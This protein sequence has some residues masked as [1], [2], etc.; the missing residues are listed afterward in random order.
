MSVGSKLKGAAIGAYLGTGPKL[1]RAWHATRHAL[2]AERVVTFWHQIDDPWSHLLAQALTRFSAS[3]PNVRLEPVLV[4]EP[5]ADADAEP[6][7]RILYG[8]ADARRLAD[9]YGLSFPPLPVLPEPDRLR[10]AQAV[11]LGEREPDAWLDAAVRAGDAL[12]RGDGDAL[13]QLVRELGTVPGQ[14]VRPALE[15]SYQRLRKSGHYLGGMLTYDGE[16]YWGLDRLPYLFDRLER[17]GAGSGTLSEVASTSRPIALRDGRAQAELYLSFRS[18]YSYLASHQVEILAQRYPLDVRMRFIL[19][20]VARG[21]P[22]PKAKV[23]YIAKDAKREAARLQIPFG[24]ILDPLGEGVERALA[25]ACTTRR[26]LGEAAALRFARVVGEGVWSRAVDLTT[27]EGLLDVAS[28]AG[29]EALL[30]VALDDTSW[31]AEVDA[32]AVALGELG[33]WG[34]PSFDLGDEVL[35]GRDRIRHLERRL[36]ATFGPALATAI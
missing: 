26:E 18:P 10:R 33:L 22:A 34:V 9:A 30:P 1:S 17:E 28:R 25:L 11:L 16:H 14:Q 23:R 13:S 31:R 6:K 5:A 35:W 7:K 2:R 3:F 19:P 32:N 24:R 12:F 8:L 15:A 21:I 20:M 36:E 27:A 29:V 4:P